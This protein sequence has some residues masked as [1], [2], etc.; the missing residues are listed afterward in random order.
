MSKLE[1]IENVVKNGKLSKV[2]VKCVVELVFGEIE[3]GLK[4]VKK[5]GK[6]MIGIFGMFIIMKCGVWIGCNLWIGELIKI[7][8]LKL[9]C[10]WLFMN[11][12]KVVGC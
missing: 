5:I 11:F 1:F 12:K 8:V 7:K 6:Y 3:E 10:F 4:K 9:F 2:D